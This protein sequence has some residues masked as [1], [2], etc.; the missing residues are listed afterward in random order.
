[1][2]LVEKLGKKSKR[3]FSPKPHC[4]IIKS[5][6][7]VLSIKEEMKSDNHG[8]PNMKLKKPS[9]VRLNSSTHC[10]GQ[11]WGTEWPSAGSTGCIPPH[12]GTAQHSLFLRGT[13]HT[14]GTGL[15]KEELG[16]VAVRTPLLSCL[17]CPWKAEWALS[18]CLVNLFSPEGTLSGV[19]PAFR[20]SGPYY[21]HL[22][23]EW[24]FLWRKKKTWLW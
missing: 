13:S 10:W 12:T 16:V 14:E 1:M 17:W 6:P 11:G 9:R 7:R 21:Q 5:L 22:S 15:E 20:G 4:V 18:S 24:V 19:A 23:R 2:S 8:V 3:V